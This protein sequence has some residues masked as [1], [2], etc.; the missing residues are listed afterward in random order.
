MAADARSRRRRPLRPRILFGRRRP[1]VDLGRTISA[2][3]A[4]CGCGGEARRR[5]GFLQPETCSLM[6]RDQIVRSP[7][8]GGAGRS[9]ARPPPTTVDF[10]FRP[11]PAPGGPSAT[12]INLVSGGPNSVQRAGRLKLGRTPT[13]VLLDPTRSRRVRRPEN[14]AQILALRPT[15]GSFPFI[16]MVSFRGGR[17]WNFAG[18]KCRRPPALP[19]HVC[20]KRK[21]PPA[22]TLDRHK[23]RPRCSL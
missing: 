4:D 1:L 2:F 9:C 5:P 14:H 16:S 17:P 13:T 23:G 3:V 11:R 22:I 7:E 21:M 19:D 18:P 15:G 20:E 6:R 12:M 8:A 10:F